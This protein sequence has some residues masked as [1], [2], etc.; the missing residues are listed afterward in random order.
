MKKILLILALC[1][2]GG[3]CSK[4]GDQTTPPQPEPEDKAIP[5]RL[6]TAVWTRVTDSNYESGDKVGLYVVN[7]TG[8]SA[9]TLSSSGNYVD[10]ERFTYTTL[11]TPDQ[12][13]YWKDQTT[14]ADFYCYYPYRA[15]VADIA[16]CAVSVKTNQSTEADYKASEF[17]WGKATGIAPT[18]DVVSITT[19]HVMS[20]LLIYLTP[21]AGYTVQSLKAAVSG[22][23]ICNTKTHGTFNLSTGAVSATGDVADITPRT[24]AD[25]YRAL[26]L[27]Q[28]VENV[29][30][31]KVK[32]GEESY[33]L[34]QSLTLESGKQHKCTLI[35][36]RLGNGINIG[37]AGWESDS[38]DH[39][40]V[41]E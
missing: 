22:V 18:A 28:S 8:G 3:S 23:V 27:P 15:S 37:V 7:Y 21:G 32:I 19:R 9:G 24:E 10:N 36:N 40:G 30:L 39:G 25:Y 38:D 33:A 29:D 17:L 12:T 6:S 11:W 16:A 13:I 1:T 26:V 5:I 4:G 34:R 14:K 35:I 41:V 20:N 2:L 31:I